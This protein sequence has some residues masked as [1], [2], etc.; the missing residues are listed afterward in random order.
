VLRAIGKRTP[1]CCP[2][3]ATLTAVW[4]ILKCEFSQGAAGQ[5]CGKT[6]QL[7]SVER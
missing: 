2:S 5:E 6:M 4:H 3:A 7:I 1:L